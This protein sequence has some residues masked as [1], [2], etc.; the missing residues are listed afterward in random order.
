MCWHFNC[1]FSHLLKNP[2]NFLKWIMVKILIKK[3]H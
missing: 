1:N 3:N 2:M